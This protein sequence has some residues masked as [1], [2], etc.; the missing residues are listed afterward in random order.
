MFS[1]KAEASFSICNLPILEFDALK[2]NCLKPL[3]QPERFRLVVSSWQKATG[4]QYLYPLPRNLNSDFTCRWLWASYLTC[5]NFSFLTFHNTNIYFLT[6]KHLMELDILK[7]CANLGQGW[8]SWGD[9]GKK[10]RRMEG[11]LQQKR[12]KEQSR[13][14]SVGRDRQIYTQK[15]TLIP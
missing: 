6:N 7:A 1:D 11:G 14:L 2:K 12:D 5:L 4:F 8:G 13:L 3:I 15:R 10:R 9:S